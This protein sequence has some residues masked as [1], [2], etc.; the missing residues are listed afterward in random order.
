MKGF[1]RISLPNSWNQP[2]L[3]RRS[4][5]FISLQRDY[6][7][8]TFI[9]PEMIILHPTS[10]ERDEMRHRIPVPQGV[11]IETKF[12]LERRESERAGL[13]SR[14]VASKSYHPAKKR[15]R[16]L[17]H[18]RLIM[19]PITERLNHRYSRRKTDRR[20]IQIQEIRR[21]VSHSQNTTHDQMN[22]LGS[23]QSSKGAG[24]LPPPSELT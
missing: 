7:P 19:T 3:C 2:A 8:T 17:N 24:A 22:W 4:A 13:A 23:A 18:P 1:V 6:E 5:H 11:A 15:Q 12:S 21:S 20:E 10:A 14:W 16:G 9:C